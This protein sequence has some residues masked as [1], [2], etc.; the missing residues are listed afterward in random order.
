MKTMSYE[1]MSVVVWQVCRA[2]LARVEA[3]EAKLAQ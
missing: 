3:L 1:R 2:L